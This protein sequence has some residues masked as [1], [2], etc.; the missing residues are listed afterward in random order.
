MKSYVKPVAPKY[1]CRFS[2]SGFRAPTWEESRSEIEADIIATTGSDR[3]VSFCTNVMLS[4][5]TVYDCHVDEQGQAI[6]FQSRCWH[7]MS[8]SDPV[9]CTKNTWPGKSG[10]STRIDAI[11]HESRSILARGGISVTTDGE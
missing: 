6:A 7:A 2:S 9:P 4:R 11:S 3:V 8:Y 10:A 5:G 1:T